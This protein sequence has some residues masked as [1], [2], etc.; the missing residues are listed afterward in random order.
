MQRGQKKP[1]FADLLLRSDDFVVLALYN[2]VKFQ[3]DPFVRFSLIILLR[4][5]DLPFCLHTF[6]LNFS[7]YDAEAFEFLAVLREDC[8][9]VRQSPSHLDP[10]VASKRVE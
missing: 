6:L 5:L 7:Y 1:K 2:T 8:G 10:A 4:M 9:D 3:C